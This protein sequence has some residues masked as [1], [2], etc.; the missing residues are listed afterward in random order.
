M[1]K[2]YKLTN[3]IN[4]NHVRGDLFGGLTAAVIALPMALAFGVASGAGPEA[5][6]YGAIVVGFFAALFGGTPT[7][8]SEPTGPMTVVITGVIAAMIA[9][10]DGDQAQAMP[11]VFTVVMMAGL[12]QI[13]IGALKMGKY[14]TLMPYNVVSGFM[15][16]IGIIL[17]I[18]QLGPALGQATPAGGVLGTLQNLPELVT[19]AD[20]AAAF[21]A[22]LTVLMI[23]FFPKGLRKFAP[24]QLVAMIVGTV[25]ALTVLAGAGLKPIGDIPFS[26]PHLQ[27]PVFEGSLLRNMLIDGIVL[28]MLGSIDALLTS[29]VADSLT[30]TEHDSNK[31][32]VGQGIGNIMSGLLGGLPG[33]GAT[34]GTVVNIQAGGQTALSGLARAAILLVVVLGASGLTKHIPLA[35]LAG[36]IIKVG[37]DIIDWGFLK[38]AHY[39]SRKSAAIMY[40]VIFLTVFVDLVVAVG[41]G[42]FVANVLTIDKLSQLRSDKG[43]TA[44]TDSDDAIKLSAEESSL[45][46]Q[47][48]DHILLF[49]LSGPM[50]FGVAKAIA[51]Q[52]KAVQNC[53][54]MVLDLSEVPHLGVTTSLAIENAIQ[55]AV[56]GGREVFVVGATG[57]T[58][59]R[60]AKLGL[61]KVVPAE[62]FL[63]DR[64]EALRQ[65]LATID[66]EDSVVSRGSMVEPQPI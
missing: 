56:D 31:E 43:V 37:I 27:F 11:F 66:L 15:S 39:I 5:G 65:A 1:Q 42:V 19:K 13:V 4:F 12:F 33:A 3:R 17:I 30:R 23:L 53:Q 25:L 32:L 62:H 49:S 20:P 24:P 55:S 28:G 45:L 16:G 63:E 58:Y 38:R 22:T 2:L 61:L 9:N 40:G 64:T 29:V 50:I 34:M 46:H 54:A 44:I 52:H 51:R 7:L 14:V 18:L 48:R 36:I 41:V 35:V 21:L 8:I 60:L 57:Q 47:G 59:K 10:F 6:L 26:V